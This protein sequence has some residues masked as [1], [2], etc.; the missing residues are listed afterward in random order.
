MYTGSESTAAELALC[1]VPRALRAALDRALQG[2]PL[3]R[4]EALELIHEESP[5]TIEALIAVAGTVRTRHKGRVI[6]YSPKVFLPVTNLCL[7][8]CAYCTFRADPDDPHAWTM[9]PEEIRATCACGRAC[10]CT[11]AL[12]CLGDK[13]ERAFAAYRATLDVLGVRSTTEYLLRACHWA[14]EEGLFPHTNAGL[15]SREEMALLR[16]V[17]ASLG[18]MLENVSPRL[19]GKGQVHW[20]APD[21]EP[22]KRLAMMQEAGELRIPFTTGI[23][24]GI[25]E[26]RTEVVDSLL[27]IVELHRAYGH[28]QEVIIQNFRAKPTTKMA[29][30][31]EP[32]TIDM[33]RTVAVA[34]LLAPDMNFQAPPNLN[35][36]DHR[37]LLR[38][39]I[40]DWGG[41]SPL[42]PDF[43]NP[44]APW[45]HVAA[46]AQLCREEGFTLRP[47]LPLYDEYLEKDEFVDPA[48]RARLR[49]ARDRKGEGPC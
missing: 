9:L 11:E 2:H 38:A 43:V 49:A 32:S 45:P 16:P 29:T 8:R 25:G 34:R 4:V 40:N 39:G 3:G 17:N 35:P 28:I 1:T 20:H 37:I 30:A 44:E 41:I 33:A 27:A 19:R 13:P 36:Y 7:D 24:L 14:L 23:L 18:L 21:K 47:R 48:L 15:L 31:P 12:L 10:G 22:R 26:T 5:H 42:T 6:T 46:L